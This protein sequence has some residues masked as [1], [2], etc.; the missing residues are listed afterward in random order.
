MSTTI[1]TSSKN[2]YSKIKNYLSHKKVLFT[3]SL[4][5]DEYTLTLFD[6]TS[7]QTE[8]LI[9]RMTRHFHLTSKSQQ[10]LQALAA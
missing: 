5:N 10:E 7:S 4:D 6:L 1:R 9:L 2:Y 8:E 3:H